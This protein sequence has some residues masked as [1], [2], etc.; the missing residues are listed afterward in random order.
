MVKTIKKSLIIVVRKVKI[1]R[2]QCHRK[3]LVQIISCDNCPTEK[4]TGSRVTAS[5]KHQPKATSSLLT[6]FFI[7]PFFFT[8]ILFSNCNRLC[9]YLSLTHLLIYLYTYKLSSTHFPFAIQKWHFKIK[10][11]TINRY[12]LRKI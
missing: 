12:N 6:R 3:E 4:L 5:E 9:C 10:D 7:F 2:R 1:V 11:L 8:P